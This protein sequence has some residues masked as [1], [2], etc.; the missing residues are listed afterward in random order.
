MNQIVRIWNHSD[1]WYGE[2]TGR[3]SKHGLLCRQCNLVF[4][5]LAER[6]SAEKTYR[7]TSG[8]HAFR[9]PLLFR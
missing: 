8:A 6:I 3:S 7:P 4:P 2:E 1:D 5:A 9:A